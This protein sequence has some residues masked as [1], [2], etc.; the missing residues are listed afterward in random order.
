[1]NKIVHNACSVMLFSAMLMV[2]IA[3]EHVRIRLR[4]NAMPTTIANGVPPMILKQ[5][6]QFSTVG[7]LRKN[8]SRTYAVYVTRMPG[9]DV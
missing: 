7:Y 3:A 4:T 2:I 8:C 9:M 6:T 1:M 5:S